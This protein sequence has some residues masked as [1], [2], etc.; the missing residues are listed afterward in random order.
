MVTGK[1]AYGVFRNE[2]GVHR[3]Q[4]VPATE[5]KGRVHT[6]TAVV[7]VLPEPTKVRYLATLRVAS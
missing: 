6:S 1:G 7:L 3:V 2:S 5:S 4:R